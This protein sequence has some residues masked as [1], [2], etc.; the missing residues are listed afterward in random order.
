[1]LILVEGEEREK[2]YKTHQAG[3]DSDYIRDREDRRYENRRTT[4]PKEKEPKK[5]W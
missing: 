4:K 1:V 5:W 2:R 3:R